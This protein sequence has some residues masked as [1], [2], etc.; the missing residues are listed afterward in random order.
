MLSSNYIV[1]WAQEEIEI[2]FYSPLKIDQIS[3]KPDLVEL[4]SDEYG[5]YINEELTHNLVGVDFYLHPEFTQ[6]QEGD[7]VYYQLHSLKLKN[8]PLYPKKIYHLYET[9]NKVKYVTQ[10]H[11]ED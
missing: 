2:H 6:I 4:K 9:L 8:N 1:F 5:I 3:V 10:H 7:K 11:L